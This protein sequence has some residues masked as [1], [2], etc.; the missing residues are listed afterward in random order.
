MK[1][2][3]ILFVC[4][5]NTCRSPMAE[6]IFRAEIKRRK[7]RFVDSAS[8]GVFAEEGGTISQNGAACLSARGIDYSK[9]HPRQLKHKLIESSYAVVC[10]TAAQKELLNGFENVYSIKE[11]CGF[12]IPDPYGCALPVYEDT[13]R[14][15]ERACAALIEKFF[16]GEGNAG[17]P[18]RRSKK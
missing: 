12:D 3:R 18:A 8:A 15:I 14:M 10:M 11:I 13:A 2:R 1:R 5:G 4:T 16:P 7:I 9:F 6:M 17:G